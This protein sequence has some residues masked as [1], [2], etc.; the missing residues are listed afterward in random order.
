M[1]AKDLF[2]K[3]ITMDWIVIDKRNISQIILTK[4]KPELTGFGWYC[5]NGGIVVSNELDEFDNL[6]WSQCILSRKKVMRKKASK[7]CKW[8]FKYSDKEC[9]KYHDTECGN[10]G[11]IHTNENPPTYCSQCGKK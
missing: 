10:V 7:R 4:K 8:E 9:I 11:I 5:I 6:N 2:E 1:D 3:Y